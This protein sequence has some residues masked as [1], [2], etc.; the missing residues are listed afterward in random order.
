[1][2]AV[3]GNLTAGQLIARLQAGATT[4]FPVSTTRA[5]RSATCR[6]ARRIC[7]PANAAA[8]P[9]TCGAGMANANAAVLQALRPIAAVAVPVQVQGGQRW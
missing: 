1:M 4:P 9:Q 7:R 6:R 3:N 5:Y 2:L 8:P